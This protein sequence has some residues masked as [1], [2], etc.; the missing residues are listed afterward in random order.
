[1]GTGK[2]TKPKKDNLSALDEAQAQVALGL[3]RFIHDCF[4]FAQVQGNFSL[5]IA[6]PWGCGKSHVMRIIAALLDQG[7]ATEG[8]TNGLPVI[9]I[10]GEKLGNAL[11]KGKD[12]KEIKKR[13]TQLQWGL[14]NLDYLESAQ[15]IKILSRIACEPK[16]D[17][18]KTDCGKPE[19]VPF[20]LCSVNIDRLLRKLASPGTGLDKRDAWELFSSAFGQVFYVSRVANEDVVDTFW[21]EGSDETSEKN[22]SDHSLGTKLLR[23]YLLYVREEPV[24]TIQQLCTSFYAFSRTH[25]R[26]GLEAIEGEKGQK[27]SESENSEKVKALQEWHGQAAF[28]LLF[29]LRQVMPGIYIEWVNNWNNLTPLF[30][31]LRDVAEIVSE[32][33]PYRAL[34]EELVSRLNETAE[35]LES[36]LFT[37]TAE[38]LRGER[39]FL[40][41]WRLYSEAIA[42]A[43]NATRDKIK[44]EKKEEKKKKE[45]LKPPSP[46]DSEIYSVTPLLSDAF[47]AFIRG[48]LEQ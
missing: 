38:A 4:P 19:Q 8:E 28:A 3:I 46:P 18:G 27:G 30:G 43:W 13:I 48:T 12:F 44:K 31:S 5:A 16:S 1:M 23:A 14:D 17:G 25:A 35:R 34:P 2:G 9:Y 42:I 15:M 37:R 36:R 24:R 45:D 7:E 10:S 47:F 29:H 40:R 11:K 22:Q 41:F 32:M 6:G 39:R 26:G 33:P 21:P 20:F